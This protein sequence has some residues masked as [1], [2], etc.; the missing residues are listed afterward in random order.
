MLGIL[1]SHSYGLV[2]FVITAVKLQHCF[3]DLL[4][5][6]GEIPLHGAISKDNLKYLNS[7]SDAV[8]FASLQKAWENKTC[9]FQ[10]F[11]FLI[12]CSCSTLF[13]HSMSKLFLPPKKPISLHLLLFLLGERSWLFYASEVTLVHFSHSK[14]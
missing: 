9:S 12:Q 6:Y 7:I 4:H 3:L 8:L 14:S 5:Q 2:Y 11:L 1:G 13:Q 10:R